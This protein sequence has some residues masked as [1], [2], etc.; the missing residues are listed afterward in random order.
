MFQ[1]LTESGSAAK[2]QGVLSQLR[3]VRDSGL[4]PER[5]HETCIMLVRTVVDLIDASATQAPAPRRSAE[6]VVK[7]CYCKFFNAG[8][9]GWRSTSGYTSRCGYVTDPGQ[10]AT[11]LMNHGLGFEFE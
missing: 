5:F 1:V 4:L 9:C 6:P 2:W 3:E 10:C 8:A 7:R 11:A